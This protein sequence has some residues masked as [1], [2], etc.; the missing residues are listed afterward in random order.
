MGRPQFG[1]PCLRMRAAVG[2]AH[3][4]FLPAFGGK[5]KP[6]H[7]GEGFWSRFHSDL[8]AAAKR[9]SAFHLHLKNC[10]YS[11]FFSA[12]GGGLPMPGPC[13]MPG[14]IDSMLFCIRSM[15]ATTVSHMSTLV[16]QSDSSFGSLIVRTTAFI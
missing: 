10:T 5:K 14:P 4:L 8:R 15:W 12:G 3:T 9:F 13:I 16:R 1:L 11:G 6:S 7:V 2:P